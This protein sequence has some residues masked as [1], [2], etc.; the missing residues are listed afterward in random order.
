VGVALQLQGIDCEAAGSA[1]AE[2]GVALVA[3]HVQEQVARYTLHAGEPSGA[4]TVQVSPGNLPSTR[5]LTLTAAARP[6][7]VDAV[8]RLPSNLLL[9]PHASILDDV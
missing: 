6:D 5:V 3:Q 9:S 2:E 4:V 7:N 8:V 1:A